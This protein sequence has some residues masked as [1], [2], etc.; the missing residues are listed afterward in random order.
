MFVDELISSTHRLRACGH[1]FCGP[2]LR[3]C[4]ST[5]L[6]NH[7]RKFQ[8]L[9]ACST[10]DYDAYVAPSSEEHLKNTLAG[11]TYFGIDPLRVFIYQCPLCKRGFQSRPIIP[12]ALKN[13]LHDL[14][15]VLESWDDLLPHP[16]DMVDEQAVSGVGSYFVGL[17]YNRSHVVP[18]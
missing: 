3:K 13:I 4:I 15:A 17:F 18:T 10:I 6:E 12:Y 14:Y 9:G 16:D 2:C 7:L 5:T 1:S 8:L 11:L